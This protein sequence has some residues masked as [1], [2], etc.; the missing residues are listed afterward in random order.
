M[1][2]AKTAVVRA[3]KTRLHLN[4]EQAT[5]MY[6]LC[7]TG[8]FVYN[9]GLAHWKNEYRAGRKVSTF[10]INK[11]WSANCDEIA[12]WIKKEGM[13]KAALNGVITQSLGNAIKN[14]FDKNRKGGRAGYPKFKN[15]HSRIAIRF[16]NIAIRQAH[17]NGT[18]LTLPSGM[19]TARMGSPVRF[20]GRLMATTI[21]RDGE[22]WYVIFFIEV[23]LADMPV[24]KNLP[25]PGTSVGID[26]GVAKHAALSTG[27]V[28]HS[29]RPFYKYRDRLA[30]EQRRLS[31]MEKGSNR[32]KKQKAKVAKVN[33]KIANVRRHYNL[34]V[35]NDITGKY[36]L[37]AIE[38]LKLKNMTAS[39]AGTEDAPGKNVKAKS[40]LNRSL[41]DGGFYQ[42][43]TL[44]EQAAEKR[45]GTVV[46]VN[47]AFTS[48]TCVACGHV[49]KENR[50]TQQDFC[51]VA[52]GYEAN[53]DV[54]AARN[55]LL[56]AA[57]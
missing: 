5:A 52:C 13:N 15:R 36:E 41:L 35:A 2:E 54:N 55:I 37:V 3:S 17:I 53:A 16:P 43:R 40:G 32:W 48:Q 7:R 10:G 12:P 44:L 14:F 21:A 45:G 30:L 9:Q 57:G 26:V 11:W 39:A 47:P 33:R 27:E 34:Q 42:F 50:K 31:V 56:R 24:P 22:K 51:C 8:H 46:A 23:A 20:P 18:T 6:S 1:T 4:N 38:D 19:G 49:S 28:Y 25:V 29:P